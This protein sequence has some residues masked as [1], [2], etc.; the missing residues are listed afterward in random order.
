MDILAYG[1]DALTFWAMK[2]RLTEI[3]KDLGDASDPSACQVFFR[4]S[5]GRRGGDRRSEFGEFDFI[6][7]TDNGIYCGESKWQRSGEKIRDGILALRKEQIA[8]HALFKF[9]VEEGAFGG[10]RTWPE[11][12]TAAEIK[13]SAL[14]ILKPIAREGSLLASNLRTVLDIIRSRYVRMPPLKNVLLYL[15]SRPNANALPRTA[16]KDFIVVPVDYSEG[17]FENFIKLS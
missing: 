5:F 17:V 7:L 10:Y 6:L 3:L 9:Y 16:G 4:P 13:L 11:F 2:N 12:V 15:H 14:G 8:R 1:E